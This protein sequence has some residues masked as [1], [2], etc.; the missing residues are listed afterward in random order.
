MLVVHKSSGQWEDRM[1]ADFP[2]FVHPG[3]VLAMNNSKV[4]PSRLLGNRPGRTGKIEV[5][6]TEAISAD[7]RLWK[8]LVKPGR[9]MAIGERVEFASDFAAEILDRGEHGERTIRLDCPNV[10]TALESHGHIPLPPYIRR[11]DTFQDKMRYQTVF[12][13]PP[14]SVAAPTAG[15]HFTTEILEA[16]RQNGAQTAHVTLHVGLGTFQPIREEQVAAN[17][18][19][20]ERFQIASE[21]WQRIEAAARV[22]AVGTTTVR[23]IESAMQTKLLS[24]STDIFIYPGFQFQRVN[25]LL[26]NFHLPQSSLLLLVCAIGGT[27]LMLDAYRHAVKEEYRF[28]SYGDCMLIL[29]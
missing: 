20:Q 16:C 11:P 7:R 29:P 17:V 18:L 26:T 21:D 28:F 12:A 23:T 8:A 4:I 27:E 15:L 3:D 6:L 5:F 19:H 22:V 1:F 9:K 10:D 14:G 13:N 2:Q 24:G 25:A